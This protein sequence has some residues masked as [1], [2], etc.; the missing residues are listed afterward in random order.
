[1]NCVAM[2]TRSNIWVLSKVNKATHSIRNRAARTLECVTH[3]HTHT[4]VLCKTET[5]QSCSS[6]R[7]LG[8][9]LAGQSNQPI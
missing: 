6:D 9:G 8:A 5:R 7:Y 3:T 1:M 4:H 2:L